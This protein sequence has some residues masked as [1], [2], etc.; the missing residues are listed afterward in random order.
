MNK[1]ISQERDPFTIK[2]AWKA[3]EKRKFL[4]KGRN[5]AKE[6]ESSGSKIESKQKKKKNPY[7]DRKNTKENVQKSLWTRQCLNKHTKL[8]QARKKWK[9]IV[10][11]DTWSSPILD[12]QNLLHR[13]LPRPAL[14]KTEKEKAE[15]PRIKFSTKD[16]FPNKSYW[17]MIAHVIF[18]LIGN[19]LQSQV[20]TYLWFRIRM[21]HLPVW[22][23]YT[24][25]DFLLFRLDPVFLLKA[26][27]ETKC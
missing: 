17:S 22:D 4:A 14:K 27:L 21:K 24:L 11:C 12:Y 7:Q 19:D 25:S 13:W 15:I 26:H 9:E 16:N 10:A 5:K 6:K 3:K 20:M 2:C 18:D 1:R 23:L 8:S